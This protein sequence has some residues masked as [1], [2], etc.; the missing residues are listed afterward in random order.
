MKKLYLIFIIG[1]L[2]LSGCSIPVDNSNNQSSDSVS[3]STDQQ[4]SGEQ[5]KDVVTGN[6]DKSGT[7][8]DNKTFINLFYQ[9]GEGFIIPVTRRVEKQLALA[10]LAIKG[11]IDSPANREELEYFGL[12]PVL[13]MGTEIRGINVKDGSAV[14]DFNDKLL[15][16]DTDIA[17]RSIISSI[18]YTLTEFK[19][20]VNVK[21]LVNGQT[22]NKLK[23]NTDLSG[24]LDRKNILI[25]CSEI[26]LQQGSKKLDIF[27]FRK[28]NN[29]FSLIVPLS[30]KL[31][32]LGNDKLPGSL[33]DFLC[34][35]KIA[36]GFYSQFP[37][38]V[39]LLAS[40]IKGDVLKLDFS[41]ELM[42][43]GGN[44]RENGIINQILYSARQFDGIQKVMISVNGT[45]EYLPEGT[46][47]SKEINI[48]QIIN[49]YIDK[50]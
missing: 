38:D 48:P 46:D 27:L 19:T 18:V 23:F 12:H 4:T 2:F 36:E 7:S 44:E 45:S 20:I 1:F 26:N 3:Q 33:V 22:L 40:E 29:K 8:A 13:P 9:D 37:K 49:D 24:Y 5:P 6:I 21:I 41:K 39:T 15:S 42:S 32:D 10:N 16:Y 35:E 11:L 17:E 50:E 25:N 14:I 43:I 31:P 34:K 47:I 30:M 28:L